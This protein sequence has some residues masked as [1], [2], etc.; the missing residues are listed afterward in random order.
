MDVLILGGTQ[1]VGRELAREAIA[2]GHRVTCLARG[3]AG[4]VADGAVLVAADRAEPGAYDAVAAHD[5]DAVID[6]TREPLFARG[7][8]AALADHAR[9]AVFISTGNVYARHDVPGDDESA[10]LLEPLADDRSTPETYGEA[11]VACEAAYRDAFGERLLVVRPGLIGGPGDR[12]GRIGAYV[13]RA[14]RDPLTPMLVPDIAAEAAQVIDVRD[15]VAF[16]FDG[17]ERGLAGTFSAV[18]D[19][20]TFGAVLEASRAIG[21]HGGEV[22]PVATDWLEER[23]VAEWA[24]PESLALWI[25]DPTWS[26]FQDRSN[27]AAVAAGLRVRPLEQTL[28]DVLAWEREQGLD[29]ERG[30]GL[31]PERETELIEAWRAD[32]P[33]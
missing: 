11:K 14:A 5:W 12:S 28:A 30:A 7:A 29:R 27:A 24:G 33:A 16:V 6:V 26:A 9:R 21:G 32:R 1:W 20:S 18:G 31:S 3:E 4:E 8:A 17:L 19:R 25:I 2:R 10:D 23:G 15:L 22:V 13:T